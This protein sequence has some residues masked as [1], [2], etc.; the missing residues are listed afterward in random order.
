MTSDELALGLIRYLVFL[1]STVCTKPRTRWRQNGEAIHRVSRGQVTLSPW[2]HIRREPFGMVLMPLLGIFTK[3]G[4]IGWAS[5]PYDPT[6]RSVIPNA[7][8]GC[9]WRAQWPTS[10]WSSSPA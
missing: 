1:F 3:S 2:P 4:L 8:P 5:A 6:G 10:H 9:R 7:R